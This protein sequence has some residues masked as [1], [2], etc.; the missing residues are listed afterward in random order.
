MKKRFLA[1][2]CD[3]IPHQS[4]LDQPLLALAGGCLQW[5]P[6]LYLARKDT[7]LFLE[8][9]ASVHLFSEKTIQSE[10]GQLLQDLQLQAQ[11]AVADSLLHSLILARYGSLHPQVLP[12]SCLL[13]YLDP[14]TQETPERRKECETMIDALRSLGI[15]RVAQFLKL[16]VREL[17]PRFG[18]MSLQVRERLLG[19]W[20][21]LAPLWLPEPPVKERSEG[22]E[23]FFSHSVASLM[24]SFQPLL[25]SLVRRLAKKMHRLTRLKIHLKLDDFAT[26]RPSREWVLDFMF[27]QAEIAPL[28]RIMQEKL[29]KEL[30]RM[31]LPA[32]VLAIELEV[33]QSIVCPPTQVTLA[34]TSVTGGSGGMRGSFTAAN[35]AAQEDSLHSFLNEVAQSLGQ[36]QV[37]RAVIHEEAVAERAWSRAFKLQKSLPDLTD[38]IPLRPTQVLRRPEK[39]ALEQNQVVIRQRRYQ[40]LRWSEVEEIATHWMDPGSAVVR[41]YYQLDLHQQS[42]VWIF[43]NPQGETYLHG[44][45]G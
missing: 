39:I 34:G 44:Y 20:E 29:Q 4:R 25:E 45:Y 3:A 27:P 24:V 28:L 17:A 16:P 21:V 1:I 42:R 26:K 40:I 36:E 10:V 32:P 18:V 30:E 19:G 6:S 7:A 15:S 31:P 11:V 41:S 8:I 12:L 23:G 2:L 38:Y 33:L 9:G 14:L 37:F 13:D 22:G 35:L 5:T 43:K